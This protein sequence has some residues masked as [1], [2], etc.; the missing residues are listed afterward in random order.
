EVNVLLSMA[1]AVEEA[2]LAE[3]FPGDYR[4][5]RG[6]VYDE[7]ARRVV[8]RRERR[9]RDLVL[10][11]RSSSDEA[12]LSE[13]AALLTREVLAGRIKIDAWD[14]SVEQWIVR[15]N[16]LAEWFPELEVNPL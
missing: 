4:E 2:W 1:T 9:F 3:L 7:Q 13:A 10:E 11:S 16:R 8:S 5:T 15:V 14:D 6:V 12:P